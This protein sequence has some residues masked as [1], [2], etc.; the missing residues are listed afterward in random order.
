MSFEFIDNS[1]IDGAA[2]RRIRSQAAKG[3]NLGRKIRRPRRTTGPRTAAVSDVVR[4]PDAVRR[5]AAIVKKQDDERGWEIQW[6][7]DNGLIFPAQL[8]SRDMSLAHRGNTQ[9]M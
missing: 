8:D 9:L 5:V 3:K 6:P 2:R 1:S 7:I 4:V